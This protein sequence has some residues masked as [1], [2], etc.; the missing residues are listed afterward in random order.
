MTKGG[1]WTPWAPPPATPLH[2]S[3]KRSAHWAVC[4]LTLQAKAVKAAI[5]C[6]LWPTRYQL[7]TRVTTWMH[8]ACYHVI[9]VCS[10]TTCARSTETH[11]E[12]QLQEAYLPVCYDQWWVSHVA[13]A[14]SLTVHTL[15]IERKPLR[16]LL[17]IESLSGSEEGSAVQQMM[18]E[19][20][21]KAF[22]AKAKW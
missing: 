8:N 11:A 17:S 21:N 7:W 2:Y 1:A 3:A 14:I 9:H 22:S 4:C 20:L 6:R 16:S 18:P 10:S 19:L 5:L 12:S 15:H 13:G